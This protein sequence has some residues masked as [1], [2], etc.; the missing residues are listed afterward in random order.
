[1]LR[2]ALTV[3]DLQSDY[4]RQIRADKKCPSNGV[5]NYGKVWRMGAGKRGFKRVVSYKD[6]RKFTQSAIGYSRHAKD[7]ILGNVKWSEPG[8]RN[9]RQQAKCAILYFVLLNARKSWKL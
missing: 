5:T 8:R 4:D 3:P 1:M 9:C 6:E 2:R 7:E